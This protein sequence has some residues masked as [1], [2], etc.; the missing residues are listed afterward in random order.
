[1]LA[2]LFLQGC[3]KFSGINTLV[4]FLEAIPAAYVFGFVHTLISMFTP[5][6]AGHNLCPTIF[7]TCSFFQLFCGLLLGHSGCGN[8][9]SITFITWRIAISAIFSTDLLN[10]WQWFKIINSTVTRFNKWHIHFGPFISLVSK[11]FKHIIWNHNGQ[12]SKYICFCF[13]ICLQF[14]NF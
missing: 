9:C 10:I 3:F 14:C 13:H 12:C 6:S 5:I 11:R 4:A 2:H 7:F 1:M 8:S